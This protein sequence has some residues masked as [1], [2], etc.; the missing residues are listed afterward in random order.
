MPNECPVV[1]CSRRPDQPPKNARL[2]S[3]SLVLGTTKSNFVFVF[4]P[5]QINVGCFARETLTI[6]MA[7]AIQ[8]AMWNRASLDLGL[9]SCDD[10]FIASMSPVFDLSLRTHGKLNVDLT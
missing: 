7:L 5:S 8:S 4:L 2:P 6:Q 9:D 3:C 1:D 10:D